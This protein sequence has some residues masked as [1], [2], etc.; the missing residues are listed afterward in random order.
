[1]TTTERVWMTRQ[2]HTRLES[3]LAAL[4]SRPSIEVPDDLMDYDG[5]LA[6]HL[7]RQTRIRQIRNLLIN[8]NVGEDTPDD[9]IAEAGRFRRGRPARVFVSSFTSSPFILAI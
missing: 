8:A 4:R 9:G 1:M 6:T 2:A 5:N 7:A 3:E